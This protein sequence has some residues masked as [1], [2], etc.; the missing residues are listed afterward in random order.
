MAA[1]A[2]TAQ[3]M[4]PAAA[5]AGETSVYFFT[6]RAVHPLYREQMDAVPEGFRYVP[7]HP[8]LVDASVVKRDIAS[9]GTAPAGVALAAKRAAA[10]IAGPAGYVRRTR[11]AVPDGAALVHSGQF[12]LRAPATPYVVDL[13]E[14]SVFSLY[15]RGALDRPWARRRLATA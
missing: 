8:D 4:A 1:T 11:V 9:R 2:R 12:L 13:E 6:G 10:R 14:V 3:T 15:Q 7:S 5:G